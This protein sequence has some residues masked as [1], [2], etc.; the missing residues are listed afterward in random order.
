[1]YSWPLAVLLSSIRLGN[2]HNRT[3][4]LGILVRFEG[5]PQ[6]KRLN[7]LADEGLGQNIVTIVCFK[8]P[9]PTPTLN[10]DCGHAAQQQHA[11]LDR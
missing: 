9:F 11:I 10:F 1:M 3:H 6:V 5:I 2:T 8:I 7:V 4:V